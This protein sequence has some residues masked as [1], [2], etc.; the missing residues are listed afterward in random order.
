[1]LLRK[2]A[3]RLREETGNQKLR[4]RLDA[5][6]GKPSTQ[7]LLTAMVL[8][9][10]MLLSPNISVISFLTAV[11]YGF[12]YILYTT[13]PQTFLCIYAWEPKNIGLAYLGTAVGNLLGMILGGGISDAIVKRRAKN[14]QAKPEN[15]LIPMIFFWPLVSVGLYMYAWTAQNALHWI[16]SMVG[17]RYLVLGLCRQS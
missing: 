17:R 10:K 13:F 5:D 14:R 9:L 4:P 16:W 11:G 7:R 12:M 6:L 3:R 2:M 1:M 15:R 8:P